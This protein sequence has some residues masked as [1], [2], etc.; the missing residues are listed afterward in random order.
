[1]VPP[2]YP[3]NV[4]GQLK[5]DQEFCTMPQGDLK[6]TIFGMCTINP[7]AEGK[8]RETDTKADLIFKHV[9]YNYLYVVGNN[10]GPSGFSFLLHLVL[11][12]ALLH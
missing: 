5:N 12:P 8:L 4:D 1:M 10:V 7:T 9:S 11:F 3:Q 6:T 2:K